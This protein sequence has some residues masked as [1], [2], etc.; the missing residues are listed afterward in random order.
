[1]FAEDEIEEYFESLKKEITLESII[2]Q[3]EEKASFCD[4]EVLLL[5]DLAETYRDLIK[6]LEEKKPSSQGD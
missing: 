3:L 5:Q 2:A 4:K 6:T 1:M